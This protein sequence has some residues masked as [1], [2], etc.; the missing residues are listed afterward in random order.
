M[1]TAP[2]QASSPSVP[3]SLNPPPSAIIPQSAP[4]QKSSTVGLI[5]T[6]RNELLSGTTSAQSLFEAV[7]DAAHVLSGADGTALALETNGT[8]LCCARSGSMAPEL[9]VPINTGAGISGECLRTATMLVCH[10]ALT[11]SRV[12]NE[13]CRVLGIRSVVAVPVSGPAGVAGI[14]EAFSSR[15]DAF[16]GDALSSLRALADIAGGVYKR[17]APQPAFVVEPAA[18]VARVTTKAVPPI[19]VEEI[20]VDQTAG[21]GRLWMVVGIAVVLLATV[22]VAWWS[23]ESPA[24][25]AVGGMQTVR[26]ATTS[27]PSGEV[28]RDA[29]PK[30]TPGLITR[31][32]ESH[33]GVI[34]AENAAELKRIESASSASV[35]SSY[36]PSRP[37]TATSEVADMEPPRIQV[38]GNA[39]SAELARLTSVS[40]RL[41]S[42]SPRI[43]E[44]VVEAVLIHKVEPAYPMQARTERLS[45]KVTLSATIAADGSIREVTVIHGSAILAEAAK[46]A[47]RQWR[48][49]PATL[50]GSPVEVQKEINFVFQP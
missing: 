18:P 19:A 37:S 34:V 5:G 47:L 46:A 10:D 20:L 44:G 1:G 40:P 3:V 2:R 50:N 39:N 24:D 49:R 42:A 36:S 14:L 13:V 16:D 45:G 28:A 33:R 26:A 48:Y 17:Q 4:E 43:S 31:R 41:P 35:T 25:E 27:Q 29:V 21:R 11:D 32:A 23:W 12:D 8:I 15:P 30:P 7:A 22:A 9:G 38:G 6:L